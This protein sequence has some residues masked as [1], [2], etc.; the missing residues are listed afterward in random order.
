M[1]IP[2]R[3]DTGYW[4]EYVMK[5][6]EI[7]FCKGRVNFLRNGARPKNGST[8]ALSIVIFK[9]TDNEY[10]I[11]KPF[12]HKEKDLIKFRKIDEFCRTNSNEEEL[13]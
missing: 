7:R 2:S 10:P 5:A 3:T 8:F 13:I 12:Y 11:A 1:I 6:H 4:H 9:K